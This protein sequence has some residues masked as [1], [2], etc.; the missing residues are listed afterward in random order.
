MQL[1]F[2]RID[3]K[4]LPNSARKQ[5]RGIRIWHADSLRISILAF[6]DEVDRF[7]DGDQGRNERDPGH[8]QR[9][10]DPQP[11]ALAGTARRHLRQFDR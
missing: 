4:L 8:R 2:M 7:E 11:L 3:C 5:Q 10:G 9:A 6:H 1:S